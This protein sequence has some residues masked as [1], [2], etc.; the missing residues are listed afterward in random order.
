MQNDT[1]TDLKKV[2]SYVRALVERKLVLCPSYSGYS[3]SLELFDL[4]QHPCISLN[5]EYA[6]DAA[7]LSDVILTVDKAEIPPCPELP[8]IL[9][10]WVAEGWNKASKELK[11]IEKREFCED[12]DD[13]STFRVELFSDSTERRD[14]FTDWCALR[15]EWAE[16]ALPSEKAR[17]LYDTLYDLYSRLEREKDRLELVIGDGILRGKLED[18]TRICHPIVLERVTLSFDA[19]VPRFY[20]LDND[21]PATLYT[22]LLRI[23]PGLETSGLSSLSVQIEESGVHAFD[24]EPLNIYLQTL[25]NQISSECEFSPEALESSKAKYSVS[26]GMVLLAQSKNSGYIA[27]LEKILQD[28]DIAESFSPSLSSLI[29]H[30]DTHV[31]AAEISDMGSRLMAVNGID[32]S[33]LLEKQANREQLIIARKLETSPA[34]LVQGPPGTGKTHTISN[35]IGDL[36]SK[37][38]SVLVTSQTSKALSVLRDKISEPIRPL[39]VSVLENN[40]EQLEAS[41]NTINDYMSSYNID[42][43]AQEAE[44]LQKERSEVI[45]ALASAKARLVDLVEREYVPFEIAGES[46]LPKEAGLR[47]ASLASEAFIPDSV[48]PGTLLPLSESEL[49]D[50]YASNQ[51]LTS[52]DEQKLSLKPPM[53]DELLTPVKFARLCAI[54]T[55]TQQELPTTGVGYWRE[56]AQRDAES[57]GRLRTALEV[58]CDRLTS[59]QGWQLEIAQIGASQGGVSG[60]Y[61]SIGS[62]IEQLNALYGEIKT[63]LIDTEPMIPDSL[64]TGDISSL[65]ED[66]LSDIDTE[67]INWLKIAL[68]P[69]WKPIL[70][71]C[72]IN[73]EKPDTRSEVVI[74][75]KY[76]KYLLGQQ[77]LLNRWE[78]AVVA[79]GGPKINNGRPEELAG[80]AWQSVS[81][82]LS[83]YADIWTPLKTDLETQGF[84]YS[85]YY[86]KLPLE[87]RMSGEVKSILSALTSDLIE[88]VSLEFSRGDRNESLALL[89]DKSKELLPFCKEYF[90]EASG[91][92]EA[93]EKRDEALY[94]ASYDGY[95]LLCRK[96]AIYERRLYLLE[97]LSE[98]CPLW[99]DEIEKRTSP[100]DTSAIPGDLAAHWLRAQLCGELDERAKQSLTDVQNEIAALEKQLSG[101]TRE[102]IARRAWCAELL[103]MQDPD[104]KRAL[105]TWANLVKRVGKGT[106][107]RA[108]QLL[109]SGELRRAMKACRR[110][111][112]VWIM[113]LS[114]VAEYFEPSDE[115]FDVLIIDEASQADLSGLIALYIAD[116][117]IV[118]G[119]DKQVSP[120]AVGMDIEVSQKLRSEFLEG[121]PSAAM[122]DELLSIYDLGKANY[123][124]ITLKEHFRCT[125][126]IINFSNYYTYNG[127][128]CP[129][130]DSGSVPI[131]PSTAAYHVENGAASGKKTNKNE[132]L[133]V[134]SLIC[135]CTQ[136]EEYKGSTFGVITMIGDEQ[137]VLIDR[138]L[139]EKLMESEYQERQILCGNPAYFQGDE[140]DVIFISLV[141]AP[142][143]DGKTLQT[144][145]EGYNEMYAKRYNVAASRARDQMWVVY[146]VN[147]E[148]DL[149][150]DDM[151]LR[152]INHAAHPEDTAKLLEKTS[153]AAISEIEGAVAEYLTDCG[154]TMQLR[155]K[156]GSYTVSMICTDSHK[157][158][159][160]EVDGDRNADEKYIAAEISKQSVLERLGWKFIRLRAS[161]YYR[162][163]RAYLERLGLSISELGLSAGES[164]AEQ[165]DGELLERVITLAAELRAQWSESDD[166]STEAEIVVA[167]ADSTEEFSGADSPENG[168]IIDK[169]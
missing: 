61:E 57:I 129:L 150:G 89:E 46:I 64:I 28:I 31:H 1:R 29:G 158:V 144:R 60:V 56:N 93:I 137:G 67:K 47:I 107:K 152:L 71:Q 151:R 63:D 43:L 105:A 103:T 166:S 22:R 84:E 79:V 44:R 132:A 98:I 8:A 97:R 167:E 78:K 160:I 99:A 11:V 100:N 111:V 70:E 165:N 51:A 62:A 9:S 127:I 87:I 72:I 83:W 116:K 124:P 40:R 15:D 92:R 12:P 118:V 128:I 121:V 33:V 25:C 108:E 48:A 81:G 3:F 52:S 32:D 109:A 85:R 35:I 42:S 66:I 30:N 90:P 41:L 37:G 133:A 123:E 75:S 49:S 153:P 50:L 65:F 169:A 91:M 14:V 54:V 140:R 149:K 134:A 45:N 34:V 154:Y 76:H 117:V 6:S 161:E 69:K 125:T 96:R 122:Y 141:D 102:L 157:R 82:W 53:L 120:T 2:F 147:P 164:A 38:K 21:S 119:D 131:K 19:S 94:K 143:R 130:R 86:E 27:M 115:K 155:Q 16:E 113:P 4:P 68:H 13:E 95:D 10:G 26:R 23:V 138:I 18:G 162:E 77:Q 104:R 58:E 88:L 106:G 114:S 112:P 74:L 142:K 168:E 136:Q 24:G 36:L 163:P 17:E 80:M 5:S 73:G 55:Q 159:A 59:A 110:S 139:R 145:G 20:I 101:I 148:T 7:L 146:S 156:V 126:D 39:C 135:A